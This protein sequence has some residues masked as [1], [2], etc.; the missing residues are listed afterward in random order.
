[1][2][3]ILGSI[4]YGESLLNMFGFFWRGDFINICFFHL[5][6]GCARPKLPGIYTRVSNFLPWI[7][8]K[9]K[10]QCMCTPKKGVRTGFIDTILE[11]QNK[12]TTITAADDN[13]VDFEDDYL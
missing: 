11:Q 4:S 12:G 3:L 2:L 10:S 13:D 9:L 1:M 6:T 5:F 8:K 7:E